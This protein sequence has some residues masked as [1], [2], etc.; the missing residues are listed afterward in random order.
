M[1]CYGRKT[2]NP[3][4]TS[5][6]R[7]AQFSC[8][9]HIEENDY[10]RKSLHHT[11]HDQISRYVN[12][13]IISLKLVSMIV[14]GSRSV[15]LMFHSS[16]P[17]HKLDRLPDRSHHSFVVDTVL[18]NDMDLMPAHSMDST[19]TYMWSWTPPLIPTKICCIN[20]ITT[21]LG[22]DVT[23]RLPER[24]VRHVSSINIASRT[25]RQL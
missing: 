16:I 4:V 10:A 3:H 24:F 17:T 1:V 15:I 7:I 19:N 11:L 25:C 23:I 12:T 2:L 5:I 9:V 6:V 20:W 8:K 18:S 14:S 22:T 13:N 21:P